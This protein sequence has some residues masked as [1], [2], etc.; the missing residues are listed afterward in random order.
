VQVLFTCVPGHGHLNPMVPLAHELKAR[1]CD[2]RFTTG[3]QLVPRVEALGFPCVAAGP[4]LADMQSNALA[5]PRIR[6][7]LDTEPWVVAAAIFGGRARRVVED[8]DA[9]E[10]SPQ[11]VI[12]DAMET[13]GPVL[14]ARYG[15]PWATHGLGPRW[16]ALVE[17][18][19]PS[20]VDALW[21]DIELDPLPRGGL[22]HHA[23]L[24]VCPPAV[25]SD[26]G[27]DD[28]RVIECRSVP[29]DE[30]DA[31]LPAQTGTDRPNLYCTLGTFS[32]SNTPVFRTLLEAVGS[33]DVDALL[34]TGWGIDRGSLGPVPDNIHVEEYVPQA[35][36]LERADLVVCHGGSG[37]MLAALGAGTPIVA[38]PQGAD[39][40]INAPW[41]TRS[42][43]VTV[44][45]PAD[46]DAATLAS[47][48]VSTLDSPSIRAAA[49]L[50]ARNIAA[51]PS[52]SEAA[53]K[54]LELAG[55]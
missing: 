21:R 48:I 13:A 39:Q 38:L 20:F 52:P 5:D 4:S 46:A 26:N 29:L 8:L 7:C 50:T 11:L 18:A 17:D 3:T 33:L 35:Q 1:G 47:S 45:Q 53:E 14:G 27:R 25:R 36:A 23:Y 2:V 43:A 15:V 32:N 24:E 44:L 19:L 31:R 34:T 16:P 9:T 42:G 41:W 54:L 10:L 12:H 22:G 49:E 51:M 55:H 28:E 40:F 37:T 30:P 6:A